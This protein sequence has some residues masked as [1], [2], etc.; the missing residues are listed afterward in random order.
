MKARQR[1]GSAEQALAAA[2]QCFESSAVRDDETMEQEGPE[3]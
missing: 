1:H 2:Q 3:S